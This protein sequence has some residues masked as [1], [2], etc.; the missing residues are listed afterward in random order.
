[1]FTHMKVILVE[2]N[3]GFAD[4][5]FS[6]EETEPCEEL[7]GCD[8]SK[9]EASVKSGLRIIGCLQLSAVLLVQ[10]SA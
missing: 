2:Y 4:F 1:M 3:L 9:K 5:W 10:A 7:E 6:G 8:N